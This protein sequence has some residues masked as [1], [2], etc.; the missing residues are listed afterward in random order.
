MDS[1]NFCHRSDDFNANYHLSKIREKTEDEQTGGHSLLKSKVYQ[2]F[3]VST[4]EIRPYLNLDF[5]RFNNTSIDIE[6]KR[7]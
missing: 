5:L 6:V 1:R 2:R 7:Q 3:E 4:N